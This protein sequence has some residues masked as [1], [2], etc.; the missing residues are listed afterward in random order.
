MS[1]ALHDA[2]L[3]LLEWDARGSCWR[4]R[5]DLPLPGRVELSLATSADFE[6]DAWKGE[7]VNLLNAAR[8]AAQWLRESEADIRATVSKAAVELYNRSW[9]NEGPLT[10]EDFATRVELL[11]VEIA[12]DGC[13]EMYYS[14]GERE[15]IGGH[16]ILA[17]FDR[18]WR[19]TRFT[20][21]G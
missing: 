8:A 7:A 11:G 19:F 18:D 10:A 15:M 9:T 4:G 17:K 5:L 12:V 16:M 21:V 13:M 6:E 14:D 20:L 1:Q 2:I 3:G